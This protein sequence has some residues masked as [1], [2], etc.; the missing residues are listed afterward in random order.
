VF[1]A[2]GLALAVAYSL[3]VFVREATQ[4][5]TPE[6]AIDVFVSGMNAERYLSEVE[7]SV[8]NDSDD[9][10]PMRP[11]YNLI[12]NALSKGERVTAEKAIREYGE[13]SQEILREL[14]DNSIFESSDRG[15]QKELF[16]PVL[17]EHLVEISLHA[18]ELDESKIVRKSVEWQYE[19]G[20]D[21]IDRSISQVAWQSRTGF[22]NILRDSP[23]E[24]SLVASGQAWKRMGE[25]LVDA[26]EHPD[27]E[28]VRAIS[29]SIREDLRGQ[30]F[31]LEDVNWY[32]DIMMDLYRDF[33]DAHKALL[34]HCTGAVAEADMQWQFDHVPDDD[35][36]REQVSAVFKL[37]HALF[38]TTANFMQYLIDHEE[39]P[40]IEGNFKD[41]WRNICVEAS[42]THAEDYAI[43]LCQ[44]MIEIAFIDRCERPEQGISWSRKIGRVMYEGDAEIVEA[45]FDRI[46]QYEYLDEEPGILM[47][48]EDLEKQYKTYYQNQINV[49]EYSPLN[50]RIKF[51]E[52]VKNIRSSAFERKAQLEEYDR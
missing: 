30:L 1:A 11:L 17:K 28:I 45:A 48:S 39:Y 24:T 6:G 43:V 38:D 36:N 26:A 12:M 34:E 35:P 5:S 32:R 22:S 18:E 4:Q 46:L 33:E 19:L 37:R 10:H 3:F 42:K 16:G 14:D 40:V 29:S 52:I 27:P 44:A 15:V 21:G 7:V 51:D 9:A 41:S 2:S 31:R 8:E 20:H 23:V 47:F 50:T 13:L 25:L 49:E